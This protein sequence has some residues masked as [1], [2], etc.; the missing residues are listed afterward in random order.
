LAAIAAVTPEQ[1][2]EAFAWM[3]RTGA[4]VG[5]AGRIAK[6]QDDRVAELFGKR[7]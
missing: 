1:V 3:R 4:A 5:I 7:A 2:R 6:G